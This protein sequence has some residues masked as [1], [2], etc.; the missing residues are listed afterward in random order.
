M[1]YVVKQLRGTYTVQHFYPLTATR[2]LFVNMEYLGQIDFG[3]TALEKQ[4]KYY[5]LM[6]KYRTSCTARKSA[7]NYR[8]AKITHQDIGD[9]YKGQRYVIELFRSRPSSFQAITT[10]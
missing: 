2:L 10:M 6:L 1:P 7:I 4:R 9:R 3:I 8:D 5:V